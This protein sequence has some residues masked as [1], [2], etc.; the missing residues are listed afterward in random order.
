[1]L[2]W[3]TYLTCLLCWICLQPKMQSKPLKEGNESML[4]WNALGSKKDDLSRRFQLRMLV[5]IH[6]CSQVVFLKVWYYIFQD[7]YI[8]LQVCAG[9]SP[10]YPLFYRRM[11]VNSLIPII[12]IVYVK[13]LYDNLIVTLFYCLYFIKEGLDVRQ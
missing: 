7:K 9:L 3:N 12:I 1:M 11:L 6:N 8:L 5:K 2:C 13:N 10:I 4:S